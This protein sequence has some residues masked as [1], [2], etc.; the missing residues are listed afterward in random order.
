[1]TSGYSQKNKKSKNKLL[2]GPGGTLLVEPVKVTWMGGKGSD[3]GT[4]NS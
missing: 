3:M 4:I 1:M 2:L